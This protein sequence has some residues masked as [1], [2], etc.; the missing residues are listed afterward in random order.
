MTDILPQ[1]RDACAEHGFKPYGYGTW[2]D[3]DANPDAAVKHGRVL[4]GGRRS[5]IE[6]WQK[7]QEAGVSRHVECETDAPN[8]EGNL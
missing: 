7:Q 1:W 2:F 4:R 5:L 8:H 3:M 6:F